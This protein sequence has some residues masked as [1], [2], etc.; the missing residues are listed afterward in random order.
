MSVNPQARISGDVVTGQEAGA[1]Q[2]L[3][4]VGYEACADCGHCG[5]CGRKLK[6][7]IRLSDGRVVGANCFDR[8]LTLP[9]IDR[10]TGK[11]YRVGA[12]HIIRMAK[13]VELYTLAE[14]S[15]RYGISAASLT[16]VAS[17][18]QRKHKPRSSAGFSF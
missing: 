4:I 13:V 12:E 17:D 18:V 9:K 14:A 10:W 8:D 11:A 1:V 7:G 15:R 3:V 2:H 16:F 5:H 6:H